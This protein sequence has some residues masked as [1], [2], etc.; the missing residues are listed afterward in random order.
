M[1]ISK[2]KMNLDFLRRRTSRKRK[3]QNRFYTFLSY[4][5]VG[6]NLMN[7]AMMLICA[8]SQYLSPER[9]PSMSIPGLAFPVIASVN[10]AFIVFWLIFRVRFVWIPLAGFLLCIVPLYR[11]C[12]V[13]FSSAPPKGSIKVLSYNICGFEKDKESIGNS[14]ILKYIEDADADIVCL[15]EATPS[16]N[17][18]YFI[19]RVKTLFPHQYITHVGEQ[20]NVQVLLTKHPILHVERI[21]YDSKGNGSTAYLLEIDG[22][23]V[24]VINNHMESNKL[25]EIDKERYRNMFDDKT[26]NSVMANSRNVFGKIKVASRIRAH[27]IDEVA[28]YVRRNRRYPTIVCGDFNDTPISYT[29]HAMSR[30]LT[31][32]YVE[33][34]NGFGWSYKRSGIWV[35]IDHIFHS[36]HWESFGT[37]I[38]KN[39]DLSD[40]YP[41]I[42][43]LKRVK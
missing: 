25:S 16:C 31:D 39:V 23:T 4:L 14:F 28:A 20:A 24:S 30:L 19:E 11:Y 9:H 35:R 33:S 3:K 15:Q 8:Y 32:S 41:I 13:N 21:S 5:F 37:H 7:I 6:M 22:D 1:Y 10:V 2:M 43:H 36:D 40:H 29:V 42:T 27:E 12:P 17:I 26:L 18:D 38:D 34:G